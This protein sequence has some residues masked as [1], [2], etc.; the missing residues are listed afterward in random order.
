MLQDTVANRKKAQKI[1]DRIEQEIASGTFDYVSYFP[2]SKIAAKFQKSVNAAIHAGNGLFNS[3]SILDSAANTDAMDDMPTIDEFADT[4]F[5]EIEVEW[6]RSHKKTVKGILAK[7][8][9]PTFGEKKVGCITKVE[10]MAFRSQLAKVPGRKGGTLSNKR[11]NAILD[12]LRVL[13]AEAS[14]RYDFISPYQNIKRLRVPKSD[15]E[16]FSLEEVN[17]I[18]NKVRPDYRS[19]YIVRFF[20]GMRTGEIDGL[21]WQFVDFEKRLILVRVTIIAGEEDYTKTDG[22]QREIQ[23]TQVVYDALRAQE[24]VTRHRSKYVFCNGSGEPLDHNNVTKRVWY[25]LL[26]NLELKLRRP[27]QTRHTAATLWL[28]SGENPEWIARQMG[29]PKFLS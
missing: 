13:L 14:D 9:K 16:P 17:K 4:W 20:S 3:H 6:R 24:K 7:Y 19:Y 23:M 28:A 22:S 2:N 18:I 15:V 26:R 29:H 21:Q 25:P 8:I 27:Y 11:I 10:I 1:L 5:S 12:V